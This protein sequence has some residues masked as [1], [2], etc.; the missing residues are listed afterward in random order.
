MK[1]LSESEVIALLNEAPGVSIERS[2]FKQSIRPLMAAPERGEARALG[3]GNRATWAYDAT[4]M[5]QW[6]QYLAVRAELIRRGEW[7]TKRPYSVRDL[8]DIALLDAH[9]DVWEALLARRSEVAP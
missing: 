9:A 1:I 4:D 2:T 3:T 6:Q 7:S 5:W 8:E